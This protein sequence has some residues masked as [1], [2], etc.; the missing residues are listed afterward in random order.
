MRRLVA[1]REGQAAG[2]V[3]ARSGVDFRGVRRERTGNRAIPQ[4]MDER[5]D[6]N[7]GV[8]RCRLPGL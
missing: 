1:N 5:R 2:G 7:G 4:L 6:F 3:V 8:L